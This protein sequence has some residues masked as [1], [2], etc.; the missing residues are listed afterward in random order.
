M[1]LY[2]WCSVIYGVAAKRKTLSASRRS[3]FFLAL[4]YHHEHAVYDDF[5]HSGNQFT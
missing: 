4:F 2:P 1:F 3:G 5:T